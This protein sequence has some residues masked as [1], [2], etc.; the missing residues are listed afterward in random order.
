MGQKVHPLGF[1]LGI[2][3]K[4]RSQWY[5]KTSNYPELIIEDNLLRKTILERYWK[6]GIVEIKIERKIDQ[7]KIE[8]RAARPDI[9]VGRDPKNLENFR[10]DLEKE[11]KILQTERIL[12]TS[13]IAR[14]NKAELFPANAQIAISISKLT[15]PNLESAFLSELLVE[16]LE[17][18]IPFRRAVRQVLKRAKQSRVK[19]IKIQ[20]SGRLNGAEIARSEWI[21]EGR[22]PLQ[23]L[24]AN[25]DYSFKTAKTIYGL[26]GVKIWIFKGEILN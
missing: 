16:Q 14:L 10:K 11:L 17:K 8:L 25:I 20:V 21:R 3:Q 12:I 6:A 4:H 26:L 1:R 2:T 5:A 9:L 23:T 18:R 15:T 13:K 22:V 19:G 7:I 24:R